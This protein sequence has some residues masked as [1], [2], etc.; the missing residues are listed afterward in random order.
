MI[1][2]SFF[3]AALITTVVFGLGVGIGYQF[4]GIGIMLSILWLGGVIILTSFIYSALESAEEDKLGNP[5]D[6]DH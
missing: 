5:N 6:F 4:G 1:W 2:K 3:Y